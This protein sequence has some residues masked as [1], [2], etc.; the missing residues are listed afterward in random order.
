MSI[1]F[2]DR[3]RVTVGKGCLGEVPDAFIGVELGG[4]GRKRDQ[5]ESSEAAAHLSDRNATVDGGVV[6]DDDDVA[7]QVTEQVAQEL[8][9]SLAV[10]VVA[11]ESVAEAHPVPHGADRQA[12]DDRDPVATVAVPHDRRLSLRRPGPHQRGDQL[13]AA[14]VRKD[15]VGTQPR[16]VSF[17]SGQ[18]SRLHCSMASWSRSSARRSGFWQLQPNAC[19]RRPT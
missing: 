8:A 7:T 17:T 14:L 13:E 11:M 5:V 1:E 12:A 4:V 19:I 6:P 15:D 2:I 3:V 10:D 16:G 18:V 9:H